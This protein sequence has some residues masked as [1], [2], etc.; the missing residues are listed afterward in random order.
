MHKIKYISI[1]L[2]I[3]LLS[4]SCALV[5]KI[6]EKFSSDKDSGKKEQTADDKDN[7]KEQTKEKTIEKSSEADLAFY[8]KYIEVANKVSEVADGMHK[9]YL[10]G[11]PDPKTLRKTTL[12]L[13]L[14]FDFKVSDMERMLKDYKRSLFDGGEL[15]KLQS[16]NR[17]MKKEIESDFK[18]L[19]DVMESYYTTAKK[20]SDYYK[21]KEFENDIS[22][23]SVYD[24]EM[25]NGYEKYKISAVK[26][27]D[28]IKKYKPA[29][30]RRDVS[31]ISNPDEK[32]VAA[33]MNTYE[34]TLDNAES[35]FGNFQKIEKNSEPEVLKSQLDEFEKNFNKDKNEVESAPFTDKTKYM[36]YSFEDYFVKQVESFVSETRKFLTGKPKSKDAFNTGYDN[37]VTYYNY[38][39]TAYNTSINT[40]NTFRVY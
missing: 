18:D 15:S 6:K 16:D 30:K 17:E 2:I 37:V 32:A 29:K 39:I 24:D 40:V 27:N 13:A 5:S 7:G 12:V 3:V 9:E 33:L 4:G 8:N 20:V 31:S 38:M 14:T 25:K 34:N 36:K 23:A 28:A 21:N 22:R 11:V 10:S 26:F 1:F 19:L 35:F